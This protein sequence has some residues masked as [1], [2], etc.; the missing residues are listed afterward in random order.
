MYFSG[1]SSNLGLQ[2]GQQNTYVL[3]LYT[4]WVEFGVTSNSFFNT[5]QNALVPVAGIPSNPFLTVKMAH[6]SSLNETNGNRLFR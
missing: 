2:P 3:P 4:L 5:G 1:F 6:R